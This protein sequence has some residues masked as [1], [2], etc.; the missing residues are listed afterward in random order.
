MALA[1]SLPILEGMFFEFASLVFI[2]IRWLRE[3]VHISRVLGI[4]TWLDKSISFLE[5]LKTL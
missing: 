5:Y 2:A 3:I 1:N 4:I